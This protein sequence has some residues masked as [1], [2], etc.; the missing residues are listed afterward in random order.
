VRNVEQWNTL[1]WFQYITRH[2][3]MLL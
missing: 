2:I 3:N 1:R